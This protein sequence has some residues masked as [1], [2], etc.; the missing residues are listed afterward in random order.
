R[1]EEHDQH[2]GRVSTSLR[3]SFDSA[4]TFT[5]EPYD[6]KKRGFVNE[7]DWKK[8]RKEFI[9]SS[10]E[11]AHE[12]GRRPTGGHTG[13]EQSP[14]LGD[15]QRQGSQDESDHEERQD[16][17]DHQDLLDSQDEHYPEETKGELTSESISLEDTL[18]DLNFDETA[19]IQLETITLAAPTFDQPV[20]IGGMV[21]DVGLL[22]DIESE[23]D[24][25]SAEQSE[26]TGASVIAPLV[27]SGAATV[28]LPTS[29]PALVDLSLTLAVPQACAQPQ[30]TVNEHDAIEELPSVRDW[31][32]WASNHTKQ[33]Q[34]N[35]EVYPRDYIG[36]IQE[37]K[38][39]QKQ[40]QDHKQE[41]EQEQD[42]NKLF[43]FLEKGSIPP[44]ARKSKTRL[45]VSLSIVIE[46]KDFGQ[47]EMRVREE[48]DLRQLVEQFCDKYGMQ[49][50]EMAIWVTVASAIKKTKKRQ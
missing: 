50:Y 46:T 44:K 43:A 18:L 19:P 30:A 10:G 31:N 17:H 42:V 35:Q 16:H 34:K 7:G 29:L 15:V 20:H 38:Q 47:Q 14:E 40:E 9:D 27:M 25:V 24:F 3:S 45:P 21:C 36:L 5:S 48:D 32:M 33:V 1:L 4:R 11:D 49:H 28:S 8:P 13:L 22:V 39:G 26:M 6:Y 12:E 23:D 2:R 41:Q 37:H